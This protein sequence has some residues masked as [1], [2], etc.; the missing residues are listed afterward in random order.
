ME[1]YTYQEI[2][3]LFD[4]ETKPYK[5]FSVMQREDGSFSFEL[6]L[7]WESKNRDKSKSQVLEIGIEE[8]QYIMKLLSENRTSRNSGLK[9]AI[10]KRN[11]PTESEAPV[12]SIPSKKYKPSIPVKV[13][14]E[15]VDIISDEEYAETRDVDYN[16]FI[17]YDEENKIKA[18]E[19]AK[20]ITR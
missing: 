19:K 4:D 16:P 11:K 7:G 5:S 20:G 17:D 12:D 8:A 3:S 6:T 18:Y 13:E 15:P 2:R 9:D 10:R 14:K 1:E